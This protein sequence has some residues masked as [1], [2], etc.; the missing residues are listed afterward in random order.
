MP[1]LLPRVLS[2]LYKSSAN[3]LFKPDFFTRYNVR[4][5]GK[6][7]RIV[8]PVLR[9]PNGEVQPRFDV[10]TRT[11]GVDQPRWPTDLTVE[12]VE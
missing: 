5:L 12:V 7:M 2:G 6:E 10:G 11:N 9:F 3:T 8:A 1:Y 4:V